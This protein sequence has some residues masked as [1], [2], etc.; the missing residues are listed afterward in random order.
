MF[1]LILAG[2]RVVDGS[3]RPAF[4]ADVGLRAGRIAAVGRLGAEAAQAR[5]DLTGRVLAPGFIDSHT[6]S[7][8]SLIARPQA[9]AKSRQGVTTEIVGNC[10]FS[11]YPLDE[12]TRAAFIDYSQPL[13][14]NAGVSWAWSDWNGYAQR[15]EAGGLG[16][17]VVTLVGHGAVRAAV[18]GFE[19]RAA[20][21]AEVER[22]QGLVAAAMESGAFGFSTGLAYVPG[23]YAGTEELVSLAGVAG[24]FGGLY[25]THIRDQV[26]HL[27]ESVE[28]ALEIGRRAGTPVLVSHHKAVG[29]RNF[30]KVER[31][32]ALLDRAREQGLQTWSDAY[33]YIAGMS[34]MT[35]VL[36]PWTLAGGLDA[37]LGRLR[38]PA[39]RAQIARDIVTGLPGWENRIDAV[40]W[41]NI[42]IATVNTA[43]NRDLE[44]LTLE[45][46]SAKRG[47]PPLDLLL[48]LLL[49]EGGKVGRITRSSCEPDLERVLCHAHTMIGSDAID[50]ERPHPRQ[51]GTFP[52]VLGEM[53]RRRG[54]FPL[55][56]AVHKMTGLTARAF[57]LAEVGLIEPGRR[58]DLV[59]FDADKVCDTATYDAPSSLP[60]G[61]E[62]VMVGGAWTV[63]EG[64]MTGALNGRL[65]RRGR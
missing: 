17:N 28:E 37:T 47:R 62:A 2:A 21:P 18:T 65:L 39:A 61:I 54:L 46:A 55:E 35:S 8:L 11:P 13:L 16:V 45:E 15:L 14:G 33:P 5:L 27:V 49:D 56:T 43:P 40:G 50:A 32:L 26:D 9:E 36:P 59:V 48:D 57:G 29:A 22:M 53:S 52:R 20:T 7:D 63:R 25:A 41:G 6:H 23:I 60:E 58:A 44:G 1:D 3:G 38:D 24:R 10:G 64:R 19:D 34:T 31:T 42:V 30:G 12:R 4:V 51:Y